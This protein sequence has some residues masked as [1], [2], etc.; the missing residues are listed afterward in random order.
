MTASAMQA[1][2]VLLLNHA[3]S[4]DFAIEDPWQSFQLGV[5][6]EGASIGEVQH[7]VPD[8]QA[9]EPA[10]NLLQGADFPSDTDD[11]SF[12]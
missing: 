6:N 11:S 2:I 8:E 9:A 1:D 5:P 3:L 7:S 10:N 12:R 4:T